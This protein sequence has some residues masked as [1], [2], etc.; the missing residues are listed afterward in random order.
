LISMLIKMISMQ[1]SL[2]YT[3][4]HKVEAGNKYNNYS[5]I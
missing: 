3:R 1:L 2:F 5:E 4:L